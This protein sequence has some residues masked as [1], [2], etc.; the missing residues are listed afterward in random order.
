MGVRTRIHYLRKATLY[1]DLFQTLVF[2][3]TLIFL[4]YAVIVSDEMCTGNA[5]DHTVMGLC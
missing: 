4:V 1:Q 3:H 2:A 5:A